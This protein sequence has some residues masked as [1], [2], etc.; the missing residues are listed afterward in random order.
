MRNIIIPVKILFS[1]KNRFIREFQKQLRA[2]NDH[3]ESTFFCYSATTAFVKF[4]P[5]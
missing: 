5:I 4:I 2:T 1:L 3:M